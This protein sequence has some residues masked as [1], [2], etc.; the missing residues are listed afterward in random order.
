[1]TRGRWSI[2][3][4]LGVI[5]LGETPTVNA[6]HWLF[7]E[8]AGGGILFG[9]L[10]G[11]VCYWLM[12]SIEQHQIE[13][14][15]SL[16]L[17]IGGSTL[18]SHLHVSGPIAMVVA[19]LII[20]NLAGPRPRTTS[21]GATWTLFWELNRRILNA[22]LFDLIAWSCWCCPSAGPTWARRCW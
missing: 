2:R 16:A 4:C 5:Q 11:F 12:L 1:M 18:A 19:G 9:L 10:I 13:V 6:A 22:L 8:E 21:P 7:V 3:C 20:G 14:M 15:L 17:V